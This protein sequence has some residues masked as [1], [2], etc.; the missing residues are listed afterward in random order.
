MGGHIRIESELG[1]GAAFIFTIQAS[2]GGTERQSLLDPGVNW[3]NVRVMAVD[4]DPEILEYFREIAH[5]FGMTCDVV[6]SGEKAAEMVE[7]NICHDIYFIDWKMPGMNGIELTRKVKEQCKGRSVV[8]MISSTEWNVIA[9]EAKAA[10]VDRFLPKPLF[11]SDIAD[12]I[13][14]CL[15]NADSRAPSPAPGVMDVFPGRHVLLAEDVE[16]NREIVLDLLEPTK[17]EIDCAENGV[18]TVRL[19]SENPG[20]YDMIFMD[21]QMPEM[22]GLEATSRIRELPVPEAQTVPIIAMTANVFREDIEKCLAAGMNAHLGK[23][24]DF[25]AVLAKL[26]EYLAPT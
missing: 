17:L 25:E 7:Q 10:G 4:D 22:D 19:F 11:P 15:G 3:E 12:C 13:N 20:R 14:D 18:E 21:V 8:T 5:G 2:R 24:L 16:I 1:K 9:D 26:R 23:P 6:S